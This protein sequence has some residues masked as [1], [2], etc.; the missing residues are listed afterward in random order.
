M[1]FNY[2]YIYFLIYYKTNIIYL[3]KIY[4]NKNI[5]SY[6]IYLF[7]FNNNNNYYFYFK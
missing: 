6:I 3:M 2:L 4:L 5:R 1:K 7:I